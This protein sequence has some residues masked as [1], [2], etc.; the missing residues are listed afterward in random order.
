MENRRLGAAERLKSPSAIQHLYRHGKTIQ[1]GPLRIIY[2]P[3]SQGE[4]SAAAFI[5][6]KRSFR[7]AV[8]R[9][10]I[11]RQMREAY[12]LHRQLLQPLDAPIRL[13]FIY[14]SRELTHSNRI[15]R[16]MESVLNQIVQ[17]EKNAPEI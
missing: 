2:L 15:F 13:L 5:A 1:K 17:D 7:R 8:D 12:R 14:R 6:P 3:L 10:R 11:K 9:N 4:Q 16:S